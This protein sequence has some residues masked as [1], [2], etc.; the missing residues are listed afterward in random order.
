MHRMQSRL[1]RSGHH[2]LDLLA[3]RGWEVPEH[4]RQDGVHRL[5]PWLVSERGGQDLLLLLRGWEDEQRVSGKLVQRLRCWQVPSEDWRQKVLWLQ[6][7]NM[8]ECGWL[9][10]VG[11]LPPLQGRP[12]LSCRGGR[13]VH[14]LPCWFPSANEGHVYVR[15]LQHGL[16]L[17]RGGREVLEVLAR[18]LHAHQGQ[19]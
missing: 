3:M 5:Q 2:L 6:A 19:R 14:P 9:L 11:E 12:F 10:K 1:R 17:F 15:S 7:G 13:K 4:G 18:H 8:V 16:L